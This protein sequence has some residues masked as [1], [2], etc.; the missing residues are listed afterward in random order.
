M[1]LVV[2]IYQV[3]AET[4]TEKLL[5]RSWSLTCWHTAIWF[6]LLNKPTQVFRVYCIFSSSL[7]LKAKVKR[8]DSCR[9][10]N[11]VFSV[12]LPFHARTDV[13]Q[14]PASR[15]RRASDETFSPQQDLLLPTLWSKNLFDSAWSWIWGFL[16]ICLLPC[17]SF[18]TA[19]IQQSYTQSG[20]QIFQVYIPSK[21]IKLNFLHH[22]FTA[23]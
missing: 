2:S 4:Q 15:A 6:C 16:G 12:L 20:F 19:R 3:C 9:Y 11:N 5:Y 8:A 22:C 14:V 21:V 7:A 17:F 13:C 10:K 1:Y 18:L 23:P